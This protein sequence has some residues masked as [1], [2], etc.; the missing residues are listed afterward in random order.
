MCGRVNQVKFN[1][2]YE[3]S[4]LSKLPRKQVRAERR[5]IT[6]INITPGMF[7]DIATHSEIM[8]AEFG[9]RM[10]WKQTIMACNA[11]VEGENNP[12]DD[13]RLYVVAPK[14]M[15]AKALPLTRCVIP[16]DS[17]LEGPEDLKLSKPYRI[18]AKDGSMLYLAGI[19]NQITREKDGQ[20]DITS[21]VLTMP[22]TPVLQAIGHHRSPV[23]LSEETVADY[24]NPATSMEAIELILKGAYYPELVAWPLDPVLVKSGKNHEPEIMKA[25]GE[26]VFA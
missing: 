24:L 22:A 7:Y 11:R 19:Y 12:E 23:I 1:E 20:P 15:F 26:P 5:K 14:P 17:F 3:Q 2:N 4:R 8:E 16:V 6:G 9:F 18:E 10:P 21:A 13:P 25:I